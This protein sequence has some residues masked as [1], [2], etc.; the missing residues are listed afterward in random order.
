MKKYQMTFLPSTYYS[1]YLKNSTKNHNIEI[2]PSV[3]NFYNKYCENCYKNEKYCIKRNS[4]GNYNK[5]KTILNNKTFHSLSIEI[6]S[7]I[8]EKVFPIVEIDIYCFL[9]RYIFISES[10]NFYLDNGQYLGKDYEKIVSNILLEIINI[11]IIIS[12]KIF[13]TLQRHGWEKGKKQNI[14]EVSQKYKKIGFQMFDKAVEFFEEIP[15]G[16]YKHWFSNKGYNNIDIDAIGVSPITFYEII[17]EEYLCIGKGVE[18]LLFIGKSG[19]FYGMCN[20]TLYR[21]L[22][23]YEL[24]TWAF[25]K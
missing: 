3:L 7:M 5:I 10:C 12:D 16:R 6:S 21:F 18:V 20:S 15:T 8:N 24:L 25:E 17:G 9:R 2:F 4:F 19:I 1:D 23:S 13:V 11:P 14:S 22:N